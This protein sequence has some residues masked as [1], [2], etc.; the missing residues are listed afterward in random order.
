MLF[1]AVSILT[2]RR[3]R[4]LSRLVEKC[5]SRKIRCQLVLNSPRS[6]DADVPSARGMRGGRQGVLERCE[7]E[8][9]GMT[10]MP[11]QPFCCQLPSCRPPLLQR[12]QRSVHAAEIHN[13]TIHRRRRHD[14]ANRNKL[15]EIQIHILKV[16]EQWCECVLIQ[17][18]VGIQHLEWV[19]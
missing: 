13:S 10:S 9:A 12:V 1:I 8:E 2:V 16:I 15:V 6:C 5:K 11:R 17:T 4:T 18:P 3:A 7:E 14:R 19:F